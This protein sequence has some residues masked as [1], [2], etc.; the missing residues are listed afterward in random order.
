[1]NGA[2]PT[3]LSHAT[4]PQIHRQKTSADRNIMKFNKCKWK[5]MNL[6]Q[7]NP[8]VLVLWTD[9]LG[10]QKRTPW[11]WW[12]SY[13][14]QQCVLAAMKASCIL[15]TLVHVQLAGQGKGLFPSIW[16]LWDHTWSSCVQFGVLQYRKDTDKL[17]QFQWM[18]AK[19]VWGWSPQC[20]RKSR[21]S[22]IG[23][24]L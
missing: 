22:C 13:T 17:N 9:W 14:S 4:S 3:P 18:D 11:S 8:Y 19:M 15:T 2:V 6:V 16:H 10:L 7:N 24:V 23:S 21:G 1:M 12:T 20:T 5:V